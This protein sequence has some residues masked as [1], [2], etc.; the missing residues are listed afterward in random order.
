MIIQG[1]AYLTPM[2][3]PWTLGIRWE[4]CMR[5]SVC[6]LPRINQMKTSNHCIGYSYDNSFTMK[7][8]FY[9][10]DLKGF[11]RRCHSYRTGGQND[12]KYLSRNNH[13]NSIL[14]RWKT[15]LDATKM[16][17]VHLVWLLLS[18]L[19]TNG[20][21]TLSMQ[22]IHHVTSTLYYQVK[23]IFLVPTIWLTEWHAFL[24]LSSFV[25][26]SRNY[27]R[28]KFFLLL[29]CIELLRINLERKGSQYFKM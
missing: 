18:A 26:C 10:P 5:T 27:K 14:L 12:R 21:R 6:W 24:K 22:N 25:H 1:A 16:A 8:L 17:E 3:F 7:Y 29:I 11:H 9:I 2:C 4:I 13:L 28:K 20:E 23:C 15:S 19:V